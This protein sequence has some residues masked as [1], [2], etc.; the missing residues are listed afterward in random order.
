MQ[1]KVYNFGAIIPARKGS[2][3]VKNK[4]TFLINQKPLIAYTIDEALKTKK[5]DIIVIS[6]NDNKILSLKKKYKNI[7]FIKRPEHLCKD[8]S[9]TESAMLHALKNLKKKGVIIKNFVLLQPTS[10]FRNNIDIKNSI[11]IFIK[12]KLD[13][14]V[15]VNKKKIFLWKKVKNNLL[16]ITYNPQQRKMTQKMKDYFVENGAIFIT[17]VNK[18]KKIKSRLF[19][20]IGFYEMD[21]LNSLEIDDMK[22]LNFIKLIAKLNYKKIITKK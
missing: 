22:D 18:F 6:S 19:D 12:R 8:N 10:P 13:S 21:Y 17:S 11:N 9:T 3:R 15:S 7:I 2:K 5:I 1:K 16:P 20:K 14:L 4:N